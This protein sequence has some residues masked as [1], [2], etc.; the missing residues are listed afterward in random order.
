[1]FCLAGKKALF[2]IAPS[3]FRDE[4]LFHTKEVLFREGIESE[5]ASRQP[6]EIKGVLGGIA[7]A[8]IALDSANAADYSAIVFVGGSGASVYFDDST[9]QNLA[10]EALSSGKIVAAICIAP[11]ILANAGLLKGKRATCF[12]SQE[13]NLRQKGAEFTGKPVERDG[14]IITAS[15]PEAAYKFGKEI[16]KALKE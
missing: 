10:R 3:D 14:S 13:E 4:E 11:S 7:K 8:T 9:A 16:A 1:M 2:V 12:R 6:G 5:I 15:G